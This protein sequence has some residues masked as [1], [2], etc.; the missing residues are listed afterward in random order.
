MCPHILIINLIQEF[1]AGNCRPT[2]TRSPCRL[3]PTQ[4]C[5]LQVLTNPRG[6]APLYFT[7]PHTLSL[8][9][10]AARATQLAAGLCTAA[11]CDKSPVHALKVRAAYLANSQCLQKQLLPSKLCRFNLTGCQSNHAPPSPTSHK[12]DP[13]SCT[14]NG[15]AARA[16]SQWPVPQAVQSNVHYTR[17]RSCR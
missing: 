14:R 16:A 15:A 13:N 1:I 5:I 10:K 17:L 6:L 3:L 8:Q 11:T 7:Q 4:A 12:I 2:Y 9:T